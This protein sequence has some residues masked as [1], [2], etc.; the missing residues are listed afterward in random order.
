MSSTLTQ[1]TMRRI[2]V[3]WTMRIFKSPFFLKFYA[4]A[5]AMFGMAQYV[6]FMAVFKNVP[7]W[8]DFGAQF[9]FARSALFHTEILTTILFCISIVVFTLLCKDIFAFLRRGHARMVSL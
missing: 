3:I 7:A 5:A 8:N 1:K 2:Y 4:I 9:I 6:S